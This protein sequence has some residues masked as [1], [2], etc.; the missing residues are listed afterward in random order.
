MTLQQFAEQTDYSLLAQQKLTVLQLLDNPQ[1][2]G[3]QEND[4][5]GLINFLDRFQD[6]AVDSGIP[7]EVVF[8]V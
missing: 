1:L 8:P 3:H 6:T 7:E 2:N 5:L 4:L